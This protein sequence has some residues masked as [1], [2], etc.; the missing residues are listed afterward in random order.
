MQPVGADCL[1]LGGRSLGWRVKLGSLHHRN[2]RKGEC[3]STEGKDSG[4]E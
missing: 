4:P 3:N 1:E 2:D